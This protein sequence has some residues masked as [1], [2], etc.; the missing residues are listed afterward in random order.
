MVDVDHL[1]SILIVA[2]NLYQLDLP[3]DCLIHLLENQQ[4]CRTLGQQIMSLNIYKATNSSQLNL[5]EQHILLIA[6]I[7]TSVRDLY[8]DLKHLS[9]NETIISNETTSLSVESMLLCL[10]S[11][12]K[13]HKLISLCVDIAPFEKIQA[14][15]KQWLQDNTILGEQ[16]F[17]AS[18]NVNLKRLI[19][20]M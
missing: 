16:K 3:S 9:S 2:P 14:D 11:K 7:F 8:V 5:T 13:E 17:D 15:A 20:W 19:I 4:V 12:F 6:S 10:L 18:F 1:L